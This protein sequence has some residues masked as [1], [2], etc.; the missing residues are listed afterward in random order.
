MKKI[1]VA[2]FPQ[3]PCEPFTVDVDSPKEG[4]LVINA[5]A[6][7]DL[8][9]HQEGHREDYANASFLEEYDEE[10]KEWFSWFDDETGIDDVK[11]YFEYLEAIA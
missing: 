2:H 7:Y 9:L 11:E 1:R 5:L 3:V 8:F 10:E 6:N 4:L